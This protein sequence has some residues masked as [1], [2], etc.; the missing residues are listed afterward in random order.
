MK[1]KRVYQILGAGILCALLAGT[2]VFAGNMPLQV[3]VQEIGTGS[4]TQTV[5]A[6]G[7]IESEKEQTYYA[8]VTAPVASFDAEA[9]DIVRRGELLVTYDTEDF[10]RAVEQARIQ[11]DAAAPGQSAELADRTLAW[12]EQEA[13]RAGEG[14]TTEITGVISDVMI[15]EGALAAE[16]SPLFTVRDT[17]HVKAVVEVTSYEMADVQ[18]GQR[19]AVEVG[20]NVY[21]G[22]VS[23]IRMETITDSQNNA[24]LQVEI[25]I[26][27][28]DG[29]I[30]LGTDADA[31]IETG[32]KEHVVLIPHN[33]LYAD[34]DGNYCYLIENG[35]VAKRYLTCGLGGE[36]GT[37][38]L[39]G[40]SGGEQVITDAMTDERVGKK[41]VIK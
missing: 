32:Q 3:H 20:G 11:A 10:D 29:K 19:A 36:S 18:P 31:V 39:E 13:A 12:S 7:H 26:D 23:R 14:V 35:V 8:R 16:G 40:L 2:A 34:D 6:D 5:E 1:K 38:V 21:E 17:E 30:Y 37:E 22:N 24:K 15:A 27:E 4:V 41:A 28:P 25:H 33:A 9:G